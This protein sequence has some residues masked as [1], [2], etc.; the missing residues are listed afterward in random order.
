MTANDAIDNGKPPL[1]FYIYSSLLGY[2][3]K[4]YKAGS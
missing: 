1:T 2:I 4:P 3:W